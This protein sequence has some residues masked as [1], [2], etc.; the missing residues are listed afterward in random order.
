MRTRPARAR[1]LLALLAC[2]TAGATEVFA[3]SSEGSGA[4]ALGAGGKLYQM[5][6]GR[7]GDLFPGGS[8]AAVDNQV[9]A[10]DVRLGTVT[11]RHLVPDT[12]GPDPD[13]D[14][15][16]LYEESTG[17]VFAVWQTR[18]SGVFP[19]FNLARFHGETWSPA[20]EIT[21][22][23][24]ALKSPAQLLV[25]RDSLT[26]DDGGT[27]RVHQRMVI[28]L[29]WAEEN[30]EGAYNTFYTPI[31]FEDGSYL[32]RHKVYRLRNLDGSPPAAGETGL[33]ILKA[34]RL[35]P[36]S[37]GSSVVVA[38]ADSATRRIAAVEIRALP[39]DLT[40]LGDRAR[41]HI[42]GLGRA[43][44]PNDLEALAG[45][46]RAHI[47]GLGMRLR[48]QVL[49][50]LGDELRTYILAWRPEHGD[51]DA[52]AGAARAHIIGLGSGFSGDGLQPTVAEGAQDAVL[53]EIASA[54]L[55]GP[56]HL[57]SFRVASSRAVPRIAATA[58]TVALFSSPDG[59]AVMIAWALAERVRY[60]ES[61][62]QGWSEVQEIRLN[63]E[64]DLEAA[65]KI[66]ADR[67]RG[68]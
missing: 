67:A 7:Y 59:S 60:R 34:P 42:I 6:T 12:S 5:R 15:S 21:G 47:I 17:T 27:V 11:E 64:L 32:G 29:V 3:A 51:L 23:P 8:A 19:I 36:G 9:L 45:A 10:L 56:A 44:F 66:L 20:I 50:S 63:S 24:Y 31:V 55:D 58:Q 48:P 26:T 57:F 61:G 49:R 1:L 38:F 13:S 65:W 16:L 25:S 22:N 62:A 4:S 43:S 52:L 39:R 35:Q 46:A 68:R 2:L 33:A 28:H 18:L 37:D 53:E 54:E 14:P 40:S 30:H 41:A